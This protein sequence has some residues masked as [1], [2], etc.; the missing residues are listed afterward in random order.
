MNAN[1]SRKTII[2]IYSKWYYIFY[3]G[4]EYS[5]VVRDATNDNKK[6]AYQGNDRVFTLRNSAATELKCRAACSKNDKCVAV[7]GKW[8]EYCFG[9]DKELKDN[10]DGFIA[11]KKIG[12]KSKSKSYCVDLKIKIS[13]FKV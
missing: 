11:F 5:N 4:S 6:C 10:G 12:K 2:S 8:N 3:Q 1:N 9:C 13:Y 7:S